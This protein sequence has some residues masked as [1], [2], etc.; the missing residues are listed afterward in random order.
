MSSAL[1]LASVACGGGGGVVACGRASGAWALAAGGVRGGAASP[2]PPSPPSAHVS[3]VADVE[4]VNVKLLH[5]QRV[6]QAQ[7]GGGLQQGWVGGWARG[8]VG[9]SEGRPH[10]AAPLCAPPPPQKHT[11][12]HLGGVAR[13]GGV[14]GRG[15]HLLARHP[16]AVLDLAEE[17]HLSGVGGRACEEG[18][19][20]RLHAPGAQPLRL[21][22]APPRAP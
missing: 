16:L 15:P 21:L 12:A 5:S 6:P 2:C 18:A 11:Q 9:S 3:K 1:R 17:A 8:R 4:R 14:G 20:M 7:V 10:Q 22:L 13:E 19:A